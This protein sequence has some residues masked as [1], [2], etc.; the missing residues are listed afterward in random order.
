MTLVLRKQ[1]C[2]NPVDAAAPDILVANRAFIPSYGICNVNRLDGYRTEL[3]GSVQ[4]TGS[5][6]ACY[7][8][9]VSFIP[10]PKTRIVD[11]IEEALMDCNW[12]QN[13]NNTHQLMCIDVDNQ[14][15][16]VHIATKLQANNSASCILHFNKLAL[17]LFDGGVAVVNEPSSDACD[18]DPVYFRP[19]PERRIIDG[20]EE[21]LL[22]CE[23]R[24]DSN[25]LEVKQCLDVGTKGNEVAVAFRMNGKEESLLPS[26][27][28][29]LENG[30]VVEAKELKPFSPPLYFRA[31]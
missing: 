20:A 30:Q 8:H 22:K 3:K 18:V 12:E 25:T 28:R 26:V 6:S 14:Q 13:Q 19:F 16:P 21:V 23:W 11:G 1:Y 4:I 5:T 9:S 29:M 17:N 31:N 2:N 15:K 27:N 7:G 10:A 24:G